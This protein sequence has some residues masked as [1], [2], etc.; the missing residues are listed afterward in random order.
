M[1][2]ANKVV[3]VTGGGSGIGRA[4][5]MHL[6]HKGTK[7]AA[8]D[9]N[10]SA[11]QETLELAGQSDWLQGCSSAGSGL[12]YGAETKRSSTP[13]GLHLV[14]DNGRSGCPRRSL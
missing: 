10:E 13:L 7:V 1:E 2:V 9:L 14:R 11:L 3:V 8:V 4:L 5:V 6:V 12:H